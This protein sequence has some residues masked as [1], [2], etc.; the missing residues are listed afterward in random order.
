MIARLATASAAGVALLALAACG[1]RAQTMDA[2]GKKVDAAAWTVSNSSDPGFMAPG[3][4][5]GDKTAWEEQLRKR[6]QGQ[7]DYGR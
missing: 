7:N 2:S 1:E 6:S 5:A 4:K 3:F